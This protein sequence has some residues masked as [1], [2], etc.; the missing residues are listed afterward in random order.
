VSVNPGD[1]A[2]VK[3]AATT[4]A[5]HIP[6]GEVSRK[7]KPK[8]KHN[9]SNMHRHVQSFVFVLVGRFK[10]TLE[11]VKKNNKLGKILKF[12]PKISLDLLLRNNI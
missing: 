5:V 2:F 7:P 1:C 8:F 10:N 9:I 6:G 11:S 4:I 12:Y 3:L